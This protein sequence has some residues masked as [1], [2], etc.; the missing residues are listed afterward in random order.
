MF[1]VTVER[2]KHPDEQTDKSDNYSLLYIRK[3]SER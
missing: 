2:G 1:L 3:F